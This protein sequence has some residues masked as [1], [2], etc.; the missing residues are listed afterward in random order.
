MVIFYQSYPYTLRSLATLG[1]VFRDG[2]NCPS[3]AG[4]A[5][6][7]AGMPVYQRFIK[8]RGYDLD[9]YWRAIEHDRGN[10]GFR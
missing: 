4:A 3:L 2:P 1:M 5:A 8:D 6:A 10:D 9:K 7:A